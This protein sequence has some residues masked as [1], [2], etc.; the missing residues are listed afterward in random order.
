MAK[1]RSVGGLWA[2][3]PSTLRVGINSGSSAHVF[4]AAFMNTA[5][6]GLSSFHFAEAENARFAL[7]GGHIDVD[8]DIIAPMKPLMDAKKIAV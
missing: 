1:P 3:N 2:Q 8:F 6:I 5:G 7:A 4:A